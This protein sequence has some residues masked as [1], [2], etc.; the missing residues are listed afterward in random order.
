MTKARK[1]EWVVGFVF[2]LGVAV[3]GIA[4][5]TIDRVGGKW[6]FFEKSLNPDGRYYL[7]Q[8]ERYRGL[9]I[10]DS[11][12]SVQ[13]IFGSNSFGFKNLNS[14]SMQ[15]VET[16]P[17]YP[18]LTSTLGSASEY[19]IMVVPIISWLLINLLLFIYLARSFHIFSTIIVSTIISSSFYFRYN[20][21]TTTT[22]ALALLLILPYLYI[23]ITGSKPSKYYILS[24][25]TITL[26]FFVRPMSP[27]VLIVSS[28]ML[29]IS[30][31]RRDRIFHTLLV[32]TSS[33]N[34]FYLQ[35]VENQ[36]T[37]Q[38][39]ANSNDL[40]VG[41]LIDILVKFPKIVITEFAF[42]ATH[43][44]LL[45][46]LITLGL[47]SSIKLGGRYAV[48][49][50]TVFFAVFLLGAVNGTIG[51]GFRYQLPLIIVITPI[52]LFFSKKLMSQKS[53]R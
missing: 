4:S 29:F 27:F 28:V 3:F 13:D 15:M 17:V 25:F 21:L 18:L 10:A 20:L 8:S 19:K 42:L 50:I 31:S 33:M 11:I 46:T 51:N 1:R 40:N 5:R 49:T 16:R 24:F 41:F 35:V 30:K 22:D 48:L 37:I 36:I 47:F 23:C 26:S 52:T 9:S 7:F 45:F 44:T 6:T 32:L 43:D 34:L 2:S 39:N 14:I 38:A 12:K 53:I